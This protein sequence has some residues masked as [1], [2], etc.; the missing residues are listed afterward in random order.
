MPKAQ[1]PTCIIKDCKNKKKPRH[2]K[3][4][5]HVNLAHEKKK[6]FFCKERPP[7]NGLLCRLCKEINKGRIMHIE[8]RIW[9]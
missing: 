4:E 9:K 2:R 5:Y 3:C 8:D 6:C 7:Y 1:N